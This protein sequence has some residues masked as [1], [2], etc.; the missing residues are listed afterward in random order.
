MTKL[1]SLLVA[2]ATFAAVPAFAD[3]AWERAHPR[4]DQVND[5]L[6]H[7]RD[8]IDAGRAD[9]EL[10][11]HE[12]RR[13]HREDH[14]IRAEERRM[15]AAHGGHITRGE[16]RRLDRQEDRVSRQIHRERARGR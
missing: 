4:R 9:G 5:R 2:A 13:L 16:Q 6:E 1:I 7:Q 3:T 14:A 8:R 10:T 15:A 12:A 11:R